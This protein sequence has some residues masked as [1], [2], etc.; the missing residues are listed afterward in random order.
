MQKLLFLVVVLTLLP[1]VR[2]AGAQTLEGVLQKHF[3]A[4]GQERLSGISTVRLS[5][6]AVQMGNELPFL[7]I[8][9][10]PGMLYLEIDIQGGKMI[11]AYNGREGWA[12]E[13]WMGPVPRRIDGIELKSIQQMARIDSDL[14][15]WQ[16]KGFSLKL[17]GKDSSDGREYF[18]VELKKTEDEIYNFYIDAGSFLLH[19]IVTAS[20]QEGNPVSGETIL[21]DYRLINGV[22][23]PFRIEMKFGG[24][25]LMTNIFDKIEFDVITGED[26]FKSPF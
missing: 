14:V 18:V 17:N 23:V 13:P 5:G 26:Y 22:N 25:I 19:R 20:G 16:A 21:G 7:Q 2:N 15:D 3:Q 12:I 4:S 1:A 8:Q 11:Q 10:R 9:K 24:Q 6:K